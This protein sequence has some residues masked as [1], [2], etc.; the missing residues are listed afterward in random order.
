MEDV[1]VSLPRL[2]EKAPAFDAVTTHG[3]VKP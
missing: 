2:N 3:A 1:Q